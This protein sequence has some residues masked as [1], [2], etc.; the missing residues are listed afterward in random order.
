MDGGRLVGCTTCICLSHIHNVGSK[1]CTCIV[2]VVHAR[3]QNRTCADNSC[4]C[5]GDEEVH[6]RYCKSVAT[7]QKLSITL[8]NQAKLQKLEA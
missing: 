5:A 7:K 8:V 6:A 1:F 4:H 3:S 2:R